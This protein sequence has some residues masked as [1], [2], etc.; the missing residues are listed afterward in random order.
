MITIAR[1]RTIVKLAIT[2]VSKFLDYLMYSLRRGNHTLGGDLKDRIRILN[3]LVLAYKYLVDSP[4]VAFLTRDISRHILSKQISSGSVERSS[5]PLE[6]AWCVIETDDVEIEEQIDFTGDFY[7]GVIYQTARA[8]EALGRAKRISIGPLIKGFKFLSRML[9]DL[10]PNKIETKILVPI[11]DA[12]HSCVDVVSYDNKQKL[13]I[14]LAHKLRN[15]TM[16]ID[17][18]LREIYAQDIF[19][20]TKIIDNEGLKQEDLRIISQN[21]ESKILRYV[22][23]SIEWL[24]E[25]G[26]SVPPRLFELLTDLLTSNFVAVFD[27]HKDSDLVYFISNTSSLVNIIHRL[28]NKKFAQLILDQTTEYISDTLLPGVDDIYSATKLL[29]MTRVLI[30]SRAVI[31][32]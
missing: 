27:V 5:N 16:E 15:I 11:M 18:Q 32:R 29:L 6:G 13:L 19:L 7:I 21:L 3:V 25:F 23:R 8:L 30:D 24:V 12:V 26:V 22:L 10:D 1:E 31:R 17:P 2:E 4:Q 20:K 28:S 9:E 14:P